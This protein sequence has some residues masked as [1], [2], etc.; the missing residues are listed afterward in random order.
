MLGIASARFSFHEDGL[1][2]DDKDSPNFYCFDYIGIDTERGLMKRI[3]FGW[4][5]D[6]S[7]KER[8]VFCYDYFND[9]IISE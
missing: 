4:N 8:K 9:A 5:T 7:L 6:S 2:T 1:V 3:R